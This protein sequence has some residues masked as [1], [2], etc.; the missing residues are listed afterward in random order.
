[1][2]L[3]ESW[4]REFRRSQARRVVAAREDTEGTGSTS[5]RNPRFRGTSGSAIWQK[6][7]LI[8]IL[9]PEGIKGL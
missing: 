8:L 3:M 2:A 4:K 6:S 7:W 9:M 5:P 1:M